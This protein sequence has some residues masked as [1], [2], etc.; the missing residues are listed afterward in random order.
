[1]KNKRMS[2]ADFFCGAGG[3]SEGF[4]QMGFDVVFGLDNWQP[5]IGTHRLNHPGCDAQKIDILSLKTPE[6]IDNTV[7]DVDIIIGSPPCVAFSGSNK[8]GKAEKGL[9]ICLIEAYLKIVAW[10]L[11]KPDS[12]LKYWILENVPNSSS[13]I[14][15]SYSFDELGL[16]G[17]KKTAVQI[18]ER[19][20]LNAADFCT[21]QGR[22]RFFC[23]D[24]PKPRRKCDEHSWVHTSKIL[25]SLT[26]P[27]VA[28][29]GNRIRDPNYGFTIK[30]SELTDHFYDTTV[31]EWEWSRAKMLKEDHGYMGKMS[32]PEYLERPSRTIM[33]TQSS[34][35]R[36]AI[37]F[38]GK[39]NKKGEFVTYRMP[40]IR[41]IA[42][43]MS[44]PITYQF[45][46]MNE[47]AKYR[48]VGNAVCC[49]QARALAEAILDNEGLS[50]PETFIPL[51]G[52]PRPSFDLTAR[53]RQRKKE[54]IKN[55]HARYA[56]HIP[57]LK[58]RGF[59]VEFDNRKSDFE[60]GR[61]EWASVLHQGSGKRSLKCECKNKDFEHLL[62]DIAEF[63]AFKKDLKKNLQ[64]RI[65]NAKTLQEI[66]RNVPLKKS[67]KPLGPDGILFDVRGLIDRHFP[68]DEYY[69][70]SVYNDLRSVRIPRSEI[71]L[72]ILVGQYALNEYAD[73]INSGR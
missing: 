65:P 15:D 40:T 19:N 8:A 54:G 6:D 64:D 73:R 41:E 11:N 68:E 36:E 72:R 67:E 9:G 53:K 48:L 16:V 23:G 18:K 57:Y 17:G 35:T 51:E 29:N 4:R 33:A 27:L 31:E 10:K 32:F 44:F 34:S 42:S 21:A 26:D 63:K 14:K 46:A 43:I 12:I 56:R 7:P 52:N 30:K 2:V 66:Y 71:P 24:Y 60:N 28:Y 69:D 13:Y 45:E 62:D 22:L 61:I 58:I 50:K 20:V 70:V 5:A 37:I 3:F 47:S 1:M 38:G 25:E 49:L 55:P 59:R 39:K